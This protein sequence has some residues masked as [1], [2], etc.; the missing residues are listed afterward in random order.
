MCKLIAIDVLYLGYTSNYQWPCIFIRRYRKK[1]LYFHS[2][3]FLP[4]LNAYLPFGISSLMPFYLVNSSRWTFFPQLSCS[5]QKAKMN[6]LEFFNL[7]IY[8]V[9]SP[10]ICTVHEE[11]FEGINWTI[12]YLY[13]WLFNAFKIYFA[14]E[15][16]MTLWYKYNSICWCSELILF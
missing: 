7:N 13:G 12:L 15:I 1:S 8:L 6:I 14:L 2:H 5:K 16:S 11:L 9:F 10:F 3:S 4:H